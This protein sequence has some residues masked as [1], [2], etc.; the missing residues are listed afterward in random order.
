MKIAILGANGQIGSALT[1]QLSHNHKLSIVAIC[2]NQL[3]AAL[4]D[5]VSCEKRIGSI[6]DVDWEPS[7]LLDC[8]VIVNCIWMEAPPKQLARLNERIMANIQKSAHIKIVISFSTVAVYGS[9]IDSSY[10]TFSKPRADNAYGVSKLKM[11]KI[12]L[13]LY[14]NSKCQYFIFR[15]GHVYGDEQWLSS[16]VTNELLKRNASLVFDGALHSNSIHIDELTFALNWTINQKPVSG[17]YNLT[18]IPQRTWRQVF[19]W[20]AN[21]IGISHP[22]AM[23]DQKSKE[24]LEQY[25]SESKKGPFSKV[26]KV[27]SD[28]LRSISPLSLANSQDIKI[29][30]NQFLDKMPNITAK[31]IKSYFLQ[32]MINNLVS[33]MN[34]DNNIPPAFLCCDPMPGPYLKPE[35]MIRELGDLQETRLKNWY[36]KSIK[37]PL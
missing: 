33:S 10:S 35:N 21:I 22:I 8:D 29:I 11:E 2:R 32:R 9:C 20:H 6:S 17:I 37:G 12:V 28:W 34:I 19:S 7:I 15:L 4:L 23:D 36:S 14:K 27:L 3:G 5:S 13:D 24:F 31:R 1:R 16:Y 26:A 18:S 30:G 25:R